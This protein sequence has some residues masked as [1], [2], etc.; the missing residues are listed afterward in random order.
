MQ[1]IQHAASCTE[2]H[3]ANRTSMQYYERHRIP[4]VYGF[5]AAT[6]RMT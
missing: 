6:N 4:A 2:Q 5:A 3:K 1:Q